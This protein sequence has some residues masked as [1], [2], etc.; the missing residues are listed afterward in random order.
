MF[1]KMFMRIN[2]EDVPSASDAWRDVL[3]PATG[4]VLDRIPDGNSD[5]VVAAVE[6]AE[7]AF[8]KWSEKT[9]RERGVLLFHALQGSGTSIRTSAGSSPGSRENPSARQSTRS[10][11]FVTSLNFMPGCRRSL[12]GTQS[13][14]A[15][16][17]TAW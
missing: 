3:N 13:A 16:R 12:P 14:W 7:S 15:A 6:S 4:E 8:P 17:V 5:D 9:V 11:V 2:G 10:G 1:L